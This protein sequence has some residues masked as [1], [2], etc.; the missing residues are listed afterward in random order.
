MQLPVWLA[1]L[2]LSRKQENGAAVFA[3]V[4]TP[5]NGDKHIHSLDRHCHCQYRS[6]VTFVQDHPNPPHS[7]MCICVQAAM[8]H[9]LAGL[10]LGMRGRPDA[11]WFVQQEQEA[12]DSVQELLPT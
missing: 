5:A 12:L 1:T 9:V 4:S 6:E 3:S 7:C 8:T 10:Q 2:Q 11:A